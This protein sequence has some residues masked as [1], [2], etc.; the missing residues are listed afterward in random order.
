MSALM[1]LYKASRRSSLCLFGLL[2]CLYANRH[3]PIVRNTCHAYNEPLACLSFVFSV[4]TTFPLVRSRIVSF[5]R[6]SLK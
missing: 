1:E 3:T 5:S 4:P 6:I 2:L